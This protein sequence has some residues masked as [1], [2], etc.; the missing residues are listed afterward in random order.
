MLKPVP[1]QFDQR[2][3][4]GL[5][6]HG[7]FFSFTAGFVMHISFAYAVGCDSFG[8]FFVPTSYQSRHRSGLHTSSRRD[9][10]L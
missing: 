10:C 4:F 8:F 7:A 5:R 3:C 1:A 9:R 2:V 6:C